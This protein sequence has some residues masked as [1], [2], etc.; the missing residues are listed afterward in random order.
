MCV[1]FF[2]NSSS[3]ILIWFFASDPYLNISDIKQKVST[4]TKDNNPEIMILSF[5]SWDIF[6]MNSDKSICLAMTCS[7]SAQFRPVACQKV[8]K[9]STFPAGMM[10]V[11]N[12]LFI[13]VVETAHATIHIKIWCSSSSGNFLPQNWAQII[14]HWAWWHHEAKNCKNPQS[15]KTYQL[16]MAISGKKAS[17]LTLSNEFDVES[18]PK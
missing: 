4:L 12:N 13:R 5:S 16:D 18:T 9:K 1:C 3:L 15:A 8:R 7:S 11:Q 2:S 10:T 6:W 14:F 17:V